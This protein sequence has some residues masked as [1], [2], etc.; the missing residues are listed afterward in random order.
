M[1]E[2]DSGG[3]IWSTSLFSKREC[4]ISN[5][6]HLCLCS[7]RVYNVYVDTVVYQLFEQLLSTVLA[8]YEYCGNNTTKY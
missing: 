2:N 6:T 8:L 7:V 4:L 1:S 5:T 3:G